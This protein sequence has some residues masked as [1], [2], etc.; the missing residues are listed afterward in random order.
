MKIGKFKLSKRAV[1]PVIATLLM[2]AIA[3]AASI[4]VYVWS[5]GLLGG[6]MGGGGGQQTAEQ[7]IMEAYD[8]VTAAGAKVTVRN[9]GTKAITVA[10]GYVNGKIDSGFTAS[11]LIDVGTSKQFTLALALNPG[12]S[13]TV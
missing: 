5:I 1:S 13:N 4:I 8:G 10:A 6:L 9:V 3:V 7:L 11:T 12:V 2:I